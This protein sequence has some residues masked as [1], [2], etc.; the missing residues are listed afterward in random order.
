MEVEELKLSQ[1]S[2]KRKGS[3]SKGSKRRKISFAAMPR[4]SQVEQKS[5]DIATNTG[6]STT[7]AYVLLNGLAPGDGLQN[8]QGRKV[9]MKS[10]R[11]R[12]Q[13]YINQQGTAPSFD[14]LR[15]ALVYDRQPNGGLPTLYSDIF[16]QTDVSGSTTSDA[17]SLPN[18]SNVDRFLILKV[19]E[20]GVPAALGAANAT[21]QS[22]WPAVQDYRQATSFKFFK[23][24][25]LDVRFNQ[26]TSGGVGDITTGSLFLVFIGM[27][28]AAD[29]QFAAHVH[30][31][32][33]FTDM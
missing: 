21:P 4:P 8:R 9:V 28:G 23:K 13:F 5:V 25:N 6:L 11:V 18:I 26:N 33:R 16:A 3:S 7:A 10:V 20:M 17:L 30:A 15:V 31:R 12:G 24:L 19:F 14:W 32:V 1:P 2:R 27:N 22:Q 29:R